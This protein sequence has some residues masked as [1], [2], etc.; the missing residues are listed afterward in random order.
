M[1]A[2]YYGESAA[3]HDDTKM[4]FPPPQWGVRRARQQPAVI[5]ETQTASALGRSEQEERRRKL[6]LMRFLEA[7][8]LEPRLFH[9]LQQELPHL[10]A[11]SAMG[12]ADPAIQSPLSSAHTAC[13]VDA[14]QSPMLMGPSPGYFVGGGMMG[15]RRQQ[16]RPREQLLS[17]SFQKLGFSAPPPDLLARDLMAAVACHADDDEMKEDGNLEEAGDDSDAATTRIPTTT[18]CSSSPQVTSVALDSPHKAQQQPEI[19]PLDDAARRMTT[20]VSSAPEAFPDA[21][22]LPAPARML[23]PA[24]VKMKLQD[25]DAVAMHEDSLLWPAAAPLLSPAAAQLLQP[26]VSVAA[27]PGL[28]LLWNSTAL[29]LLNRGALSPHPQ[30]LSCS[31]TAAAATGDAAMMQRIMATMMMRA[32]DQKPLGNLG[33]CSNNAVMAAGPTEAMRMAVRQTSCSTRPVTPLSGTI[34]SQVITEHDILYSLSG[35]LD[36]DDEEE[37]NRDR[38]MMKTET[39]DGRVVRSHAVALSHNEL[40][41]AHDEPQ[42]QQPLPQAESLLFQAASVGFSL[43]TSSTSAVFSGSSST[44]L[45][46]TAAANPSIVTRRRSGTEDDLANLSDG[47]SSTSSSSSCS[48]ASATSPSPFRRES[49]VGG[50]PAVNSHSSSSLS[51]HNKVC[52]VPGCVKLSQ[53]RGKCKAHGGGSRCQHPNCS[54]SSQMGGRCRVHGGLKLCSISGCSKGAQRDGKC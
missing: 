45:A 46:A 34:S 18:T 13:Q 47:R 22:L 53:T 40:L 15:Q 27:A 38:K 12:F 25:G 24:V 30:V 51:S 11:S 2:E 5:Q 10:G 4:N 50:I 7:Q 52:S 41:E 33:I 26:G 1:F 31:P 9:L 28:P 49:Q 37:E 48:P 35:S 20:I 3:E 54:K 8:S 21:L 6:M 17:S 36:D 44:D 43:S 32:A 23:A 39:A 14:T 29:P 19:S 42:H 16:R